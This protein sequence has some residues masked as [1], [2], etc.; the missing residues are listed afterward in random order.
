MQFSEQALQDLKQ[1]LTQDMG[2]DL[3][4][5][6]APEELQEMGLFLLSVTANALK[7][8]SHKAMAPTDSGK[9]V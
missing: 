9:S 1:I 7:R 3:V 4:D 6:L 2:K 5:E 8:K